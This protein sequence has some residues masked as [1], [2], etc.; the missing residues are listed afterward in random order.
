MRGD[1]CRCCAAAHPHPR[2]RARLR[3]RRARIGDPVPERNVALAQTFAK[4][5]IAAFGF[6]HCHTLIYETNS[7]T[8]SS[9]ER[10]QIR[11]GMGTMQC[12]AHSYVFSRYAFFRKCM[13]ERKKMQKRTTVSTARVAR[14]DPQN[15]LG[16][17]IRPP[18]T[19][20]GLR[21]SV[22][23][24]TRCPSLQ[25]PRGLPS[26]KPRCRPSPWLGHALN[27]H[28]WAARPHRK[29]ARALAPTPVTARRDPG[30]LKALIALRGLYQGQS[31]EGRRPDG[32]GLGDLSAGGG[33]ARGRQP[34]TAPST[35][36]SWSVIYISACGPP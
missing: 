19:A 1:R 34:T 21:C 28:L 35:R 32:P 30:R 12:A 10:T 2:T 13:N 6:L 26:G 11:M 4:S 31:R 9:L 23:R 3:A 8:L 20:L 17:V 16:H 25:R 29:S 5:S 33:R 18:A 14:I 36:S 27:M 7:C 15:A 22:S 24:L